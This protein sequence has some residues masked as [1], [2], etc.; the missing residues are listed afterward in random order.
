V[1]LDAI[2][3]L[4]HAAAEAEFVRCCGSAAWARAMAAARPFAS[5]DAMA[6]AGDAIWRSL[7]PVDWLEAFAAHPKIGEQAR[8]SWSAREQAGMQAADGGVRHRLAAGN[9]EY[10]SRFGYI[11][12]ICAT[13]KT[14]ADMLAAL[15]ARLSNDPAV[16]LRVASEEQRKIA[17]LRLAKLMDGD[18]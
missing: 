16:E 6:G 4:D 15:E 14:A 12:I 18:S 10:Q 8:T 17:R 1:T 3:H 13:G 11:F 7:T 2:N 5:V 9:T